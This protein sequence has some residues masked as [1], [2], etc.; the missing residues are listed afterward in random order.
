MIL[1]LVAALVAA[2]A[3]FVGVGALTG[4]FAFSQRQLASRAVTL[5]RHSFST[6]ESAPVGEL[7]LKEDP[8][9]RNASLRAMLGR[10]SW[11]GNRVVLLD[12][13]QVP[14]KVSEYVAVL[15]AVFV[16]LTAIVSVLSGLLVAGLGFGLVGVI[17]V[18]SWLKSRAARRLQ[19]FNKQL[20]IALQMM[21]TSLKSGFGLT[22]A[23]TTVARDMDA[24]L[25][26]EF[27]R[28]LAEARVGGSFEGALA[29]L[30]QRVASTDL[31][32]VARAME[33]HRRVG[34]DLAGVL[35]SVASTMR[36]REELR[37]H[38]LALTAQQRFGGMLVGLMPLWVVG[39]FFV[40]NPKFIS[41]LWTEPLGRI[42]LIIG[43]C[44]E[45]MAFVLMRRITK[46]E[47]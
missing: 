20:P 9:A 1:E 18:E 6:E 2:L 44:L 36:E 25:A 30:V 24:P 38:I 4:Q 14:L 40:T 10:F 27:E 31:Q 12:R 17:V 23:T 21:S 32:I 7:I 8:L 47:V 43:A 39:F 35:D 29:A 15:A 16:A 33:V 11:A 45:A 42:L 26:L 41:P 37:G 46:I 22:E 3:V 13:A 34:G 28:L 5:T 19:L